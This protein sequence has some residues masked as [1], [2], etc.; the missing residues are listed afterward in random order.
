MRVI[1]KWAFCYMFHNEYMFQYS[2][3]IMFQL[4]TYQPF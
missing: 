1:K 2:S 3:E 4:E